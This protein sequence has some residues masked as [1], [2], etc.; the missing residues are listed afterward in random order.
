MMAECIL[1][2]GLAGVIR[3]FESPKGKVLLF[4]QML[5]PAK[6]G[7][8]HPWGRAAIQGDIPI[9]AAWPE[10]VADRLGLPCFDPRESHYGMMLT[11]P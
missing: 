1:L 10:D 8:E 7:R 5:L 9:R 2:A 4:E 11:A 3:H 6:D